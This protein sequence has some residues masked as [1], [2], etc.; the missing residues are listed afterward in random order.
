MTTNP[1]RDPYRIEGPAQVCFSGGRTSGYMLYRILEANNGLPPDCFVTFEN[2]GKEREETLVFVRE[3][4]RRWNVP[5][6]WLEWAGFIEGRPQRFFRYR[7][8]TFETA[9]RDGEPFKQLT[10]A[11]KMIPNPVARICTLNL[12]VRTGAAFM[13]DQGFDEWD[14][15]FGIRSDEPSRV[16]RL[17]DPNRDTSAGVPLLP[18]ARA[19][20]TK[21]DVLAFWR[22]QP[23]D[24]ALDPRLDLGNCDLCFLKGRNQLVRALVA[25]PRLA[26][27]WID[28]EVERGATFRIDRPDYTNLRREALFYAKQIP[29]DFASQSE[30]V[31]ETS[32]ADCVCGD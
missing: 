19:Q 6:Y 23:F 26:D 3:C 15:V 31:D 14:C 11:V 4:A 18:L 2:T 27:W 22:S 13:R 17:L 32:L 12:K 21:A 28:R 30:D 29:L 24:L 7:I 8:V 20:V 25:E 16:A 10:Q 1:P 9:S 5:V